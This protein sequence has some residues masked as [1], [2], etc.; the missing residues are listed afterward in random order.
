MVK[1]SAQERSRVLRLHV[2]LAMIERS[3]V[4]EEVLAGLAI[5]MESS[6]RGA[7]K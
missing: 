7:V 6:V 3:G 1:R 4:Q 5:F 2:T